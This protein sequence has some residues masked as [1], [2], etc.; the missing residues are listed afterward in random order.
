MKLSKL[1]LDNYRCFAS[2]DIELHPELT[3]FI[4]ENGQGKSTLLDAIRIALWPYVSSF[5]LSR[6]AVND[7]GNA[8]AVD[9]VR[10]LKL[11]SGDMA[12]QLP[13]RI[14]M[15]G[16]F[17]SGQEKTWIRYRDKE[18]KQTKTKDDGATNLMREWAG[19]LQNQIRDPAKRPLNLPVFGYYGTGRLWAQKRLT[20]AT[21]GKDDTQET[22]FYVRTFAY[23]NCLDPASSYK[24]FKEWFIWAFESYRELQIKQ[25]EGSAAQ[26]DITAA[27]ERIEV[28][29]QVVDIFLRPTTGWH[30]LEYS[31]SHEKSLVLHHEKHGVLKVDSLSDG[32]RSVLAMVGDIAYRCIK[33]NPHLGAR[34]A[35]ETKGVV[36]IDEVDMHLHPSWQQTV[37][38]QLR[39]AFP[40]VQFIVTTHSP[41]VLSTVRREN[42]RVIGLN[43]EGRMIA[44]PPLAMTYGEPSGFVMHSVMQVDPQPPVLEKQD[45]QRLTEL[46]DQ[47]DYAGAEALEL[48]QRLNALLGEQHP[49]LQ[50][51]QRSIQRQK[52]LKA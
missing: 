32:I 11:D 20:E 6:N 43:R 49:Q 27:R 3:V 48:T 41:Q 24:H 28:V 34:A 9:D 44:E 18:A 35:L 39:Q 30:T 17:G 22:D 16:D 19:V 23:L 5:D 33:L 42:I 29:Q 4:A 10:L 7:S 37:L 25:L 13:T 45:L 50:R 52:A 2:I 36:L 40:R 26:G 1:H 12:R 21:K 31:I 47:G 8:I 14:E 51:L 46:V 38:G 15:T